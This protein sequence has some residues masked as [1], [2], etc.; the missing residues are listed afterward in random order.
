MNVIEI[1]IDKILAEIKSSEPTKVVLLLPCFQGSD[2]VRWASKIKQ[3]R[4]I[5][6]LRVPQGRFQFSAPDS[7]RLPAELKVGGFSS[8]S[9]FGCF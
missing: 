9:K 1:V 5:R 6:L 7:Y 2:C 8:Q 4:G 3:A